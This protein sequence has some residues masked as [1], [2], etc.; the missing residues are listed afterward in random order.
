MAFYTS[1]IYIE[2]NEPLL[3]VLKTDPML[4]E[5]LFYLHG[6][7][8]PDIETKYKT[9]LPTNGLIVIREVC[10]P[11]QLESEHDESKVHQINHEPIL[12]WWKLK[13]P[14][15]LPV[16]TPSAIP[17]LAFGK[18]HLNNKNNPLPPIEF[19]QFLKQLSVNQKVS[20]VFYHHYSAYE[21]ELA[22]SEYAWIFGKED[23]VLI[24][25]AT[26]PYNIVQYASGIEPKIIN[27]D[28]TG[29]SQPILLIVMKTLE[30][31][32]HRF[33]DRRPYFYNFRWNDYRV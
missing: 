21:D 3:A 26:E 18:I 15:N 7:Y 28:R 31:S 17:T 16:I 8:P 14:A 1:H 25:H 23:T 11:S 19:L 6:V 9:V 30:V 4:S 20:V 13:G 22:N 24:R 2:A 10:D 5:G 12:S 32:L 33:D 27:S 29:Y